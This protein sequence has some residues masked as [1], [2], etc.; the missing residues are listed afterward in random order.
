MILPFIGKKEK[1]VEIAFNRDDILDI[2]WLNIENARQKM[3][4]RVT[5]METNVETDMETGRGRIIYIVFFLG[6]KGETILEKEAE[7]DVE[8]DF[9][10]REIELIKEHATQYLIS[11]GNDV[12]EEQIEKMFKIRKR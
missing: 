12:V 10:N 8:L 4:D 1:P 2:E 5:D 6:H 11:D 3:K 9:T 7:Q